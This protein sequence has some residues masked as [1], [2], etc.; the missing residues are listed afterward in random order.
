MAAKKTTTKTESTAITTKPA[1]NISLLRT[2]MSEVTA[3]LEAMAALLSKPEVPADVLAAAYALIDGTWQKII[4]DQREAVRLAL[5]SLH[6]QA[7]QDE[8]T[9][10]YD[11]KT[12]VSK[13]TERKGRDPEWNVLLAQARAKG[14]SEADIANQIVSWEYDMEK[15]RKHFTPEELEAMRPALSKSLSLKVR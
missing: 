12:Y 8:V 1:T 2:S 3:G 15:A 6:E 4:K 5:M 13:I 11:G 9:Y 7:A 10:G 14:L